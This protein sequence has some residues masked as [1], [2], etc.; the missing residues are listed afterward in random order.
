MSSTAIDRDELAYVTYSVPNRQVARF[1]QRDDRTLFPLHIPR[2]PRCADMSPQAELRHH[3][4]DLGWECPAILDAVEHVDDI[5]FDVVS[6]IHMD[7]WSEGRVVLIGDAAAC[8][9]CSVAK[10]RDSR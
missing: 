2:R 9:R 10:A 1:A 7:R 6:Q 8:I 4:R 5:Y 3:F